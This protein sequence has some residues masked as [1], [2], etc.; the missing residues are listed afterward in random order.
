MDEAAAAMDG[1]LITGDPMRFWS[2]ASIDSRTIGRGQLFFALDGETSDGHRFVASAIEAGAAGAVVSQDVEG[3]GTDVG[4]IRVDDAFGALHALTRHV[5]AGV[6]QRLVA[7]TGS[8]GKTSTKELLAAMLASRFRVARSPGNLNNLLGFPLALL[9]IPEDTE[10][11]VA[12]MGMS[13]PGE[14]GRI[15]RLGRPDV[16]VFTNVKAAHLEFFDSLRAV[17][18]AKAELLEGL[19][20]GGLVVANRDDEEVRRIGERYDGPV[21]W[22]GLAEGADV[23]AVEIRVSPDRP[24]SRFLLAHGEE[25]QEIAL[26]LHGLYNI[27]NCLAA[28]A[29]A[30]SLGLTLQEIATGVET[31]E[32]PEM[33]GVVHVLEMGV[34]VIDDSYNSNPFAL[35]RALESAAAL[36]A[37][38]RWAVLGDML[39]L[40][41]DGAE[42]HRRAGAQAAAHGFMSVWGVGEAA[43]ELVRAAEEHGAVSRWHADAEAA[44]AAAVSELQPGDLVLIKGS[45][46][47][48][49]ERVVR[50]LLAAGEKV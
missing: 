34:T 50:A 11:M 17:G 31:V 37:V 1:T 13:E 20:E 47:I 9:G 40:G 26:P 18:D 8:A 38:R 43:R 41:A 30:I 24:G 6:P 10:L 3:A 7:I 49:L 19:A 42:M 5:R 27:D 21:I 36:P 12:E 44:A 48:G 46:G 23:R 29:A 35:E 25:S 15:S 32:T 14:L 39:E 33:R 45:R 4:V 2:G 28:A 16:A 22:Y